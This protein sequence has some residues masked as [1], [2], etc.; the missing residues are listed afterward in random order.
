M[1]IYFSL[2]SLFFS[3]LYSANESTFFF[4]FC[5]RIFRLTLS[6]FITSKFTLFM[7]LT[8]RPLRGRGKVW[9]SLENEVWV[10]HNPLF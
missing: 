4:F 6:R 5:L 1:W 9:I 8:F 2:L 3:A 7:T 10:R